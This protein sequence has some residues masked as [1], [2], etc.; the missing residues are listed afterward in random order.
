MEA[1]KVWKTYKNISLIRKMDEICFPDEIRPIIGRRDRH[2]WI[3]YVEDMPVAYAG[4]RRH[5]N[6]LSLSRVGVLPEY[7]GNGIQKMLIASRL[8]FACKVGA[9]KVVTY[10]SR[11]NSHSIYNLISS[12]F[13]HWVP[14][15]RLYFGEEF[16]Y[17]HISDF[18]L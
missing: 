7:R 3:V 1:K 9:S 12:G 16:I 10:T 15:K 11:C 17:W 18:C 2:W 8:E 6:Y 14:D 5:L 13:T 4:A